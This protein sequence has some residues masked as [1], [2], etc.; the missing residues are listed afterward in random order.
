MDYIIPCVL[1]MWLIVI[2]VITYRGNIAYI[3]WYN[4]FKVTKE[5]TYKFAKVMGRGAMVI[6]GSISFTSILQMILNL[7]ALWWIAIVGIV[8]GIFC[9]V[10]GLIKYNHGIF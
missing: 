6:G 4:R 2:G 8:L 10:Y 1:G 7:E 3:H 9:M 5:N